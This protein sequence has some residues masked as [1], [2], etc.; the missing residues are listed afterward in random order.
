MPIRWYLDDSSD[1]IASWAQGRI[2]PDDIYAF[3]AAAERR[4]AGTTI[5]AHLH[6][7]GDA[8][9]DLLRLAELTGVASRIRALMA[10]M[11]TPWFKTAI[12]SATA[13]QFGVT[14]MVLGLVGADVPCEAFRDVA[15]AA[16]WLGLDSDEAQA[17]LNRLRPDLAHGA[18]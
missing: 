7:S 14:R 12:I 6:V 4:L 2:T 3:I 10:V 5:R 17:L 16:A 9:P 8:S 15:S 13:V 1:V 11:P 18:A